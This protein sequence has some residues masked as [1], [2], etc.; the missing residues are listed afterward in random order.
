MGPDHK[1]A[2]PCTSL[3][4]NLLANLFA[5]DSRSATRLT[6]PILWRDSL[7]KMPRAVHSV[8]AVGRHHCHQHL[9]PGLQAEVREVAAQ[10][11][12]LTKP[13]PSPEE[14][15]LW[16]LPL[17]QEGAVPSACGHGDN[18][19]HSDPSCHTLGRWR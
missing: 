2:S 4:L 18:S 5:M 19:E 7:R 13:A 11:Q 6:H 16:P 17:T 9:D 12:G 15:F 14:H 1:L 3:A 10:S 8:D